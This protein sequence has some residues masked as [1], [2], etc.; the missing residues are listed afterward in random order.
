MAQDYLSFQDGC[1]SISTPWG[2]AAHGS[3]L[4]NGGVVPAGEWCERGYACHHGHWKISVGRV[5]KTAFRLKLENTGS[6][7]VHLDTVCFAHWNPSAFN[8]PLQTWEF[9]ELIFS[10]SFMSLKSGVKCVGRKAPNMDFIEPGSLFTVYQHEDGDA[11]LLGVLPPIGQAFS[12][13][14]TLHSDPHCEGTF[15]FEIRHHFGCLVD[16]GCEVQTSAVTALAGKSGGE[17]MVDYGELWY[18]TL[19]RKHRRKPMI[20]WN[21]WD[22]YSGAVTRKSVDEEMASAGRLFSDTL[23]VFV[24]DEGWETQWGSWEPNVKFN[25]DLEGFCRH[26]KNRGYT[27]GIWTAPL[28]VNTYNPIF[29]EN[30]EWFASRSDGQLQTDSYAYGPMAYLDVT[31]PRV[32]EWIGDIFI[33]LRAAGFEYFKV[34]F[35]QCILNAVRFGDPHVGRNELI[36]LAFKTIREAIGDDT[37]LLS[38][39]APFESVVGLVDAVRV[40]GDIHIYWGHVLKNAASLSTSWWMHGKLWNCDPEFLVVR[41]PDTAQ[42]PYGRRRFVTPM[43]PDRGWTSGREFTEMEARTYAFLIHLSGG[44]VILGDSLEKLKPAGIEIVRRVLQ[45]RSGPSIPVDLFESEQDLP[46]IWVNRGDIDTL[47]GLF[48]WSD[49]TSRIHFDQSDYRIPGKAF[50]FWTGK[51][52]KAIPSRMPRR[53]SIALRFIH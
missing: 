26:A 30:P 7:P 46:R 31:N 10:G 37:Y 35:C 20:G 34:D 51:E 8:T 40:T 5:S 32:L 48:N 33:R 6:E 16:P 39:G 38:C 49:K 47:V 17:L 21:S 24:I 14:V 45:P 13:L 18:E 53:S 43:G 3:V 1:L 29:L 42:P 52:I 2:K 9:R 27:P 4:V 36:R 41:G 50:D 23:K 28:L 44:D 25:G 22:Y 11:L 15:G 12:E 19:D